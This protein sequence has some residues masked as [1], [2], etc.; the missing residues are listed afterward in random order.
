[1]QVIDAHQHFWKI[2]RGDYFWMDDS[3]AAIRRDTLPPDL[4]AIAPPLGVTATVVVQ[5][6]ATVE[7]TEFLLSLAKQHNW[8]QGVVGWVDLTLESAHETL[9]TLARDPHFKGIRP[10]LQD[11]EDSHW[12]LQPVVIENLKQLAKL[13]LS[14]DALIT[15]RHL[16][17]INQLANEIPELPMVI[18]HC[19]KPV[20]AAGNA[21]SDDWHKGM[22]QLAEHPQ[23]YC[24]LSGLANEYGNG[25][26]ADTLSPIA[27]CVLEC[28]GAE[29]VMWGSDW[30]V[31]ELVGEY[32]DWLQAAKIMTQHCSESERQALFSGTAS[33]FYRL[34]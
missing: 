17:I 28:F 33:R 22:R 24:K 14:M 25:W 32:G 12:I 30:P 23:I 19:A 4:Q 26:S 16:E 9:A 27:Q 15:P 5:A 3:V 21:A 6:A 11:I 10:M 20:I 29:R 8:I 13:G 7:E 31:L 18:D 2:D 1:M 34:N